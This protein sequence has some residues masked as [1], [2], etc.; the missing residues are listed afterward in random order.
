MEKLQKCEFTKQG[1][2]SCNWKDTLHAV[3]RIHRVQCYWTEPYL[4]TAE[5]YPN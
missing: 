1:I 4:E 2:L 3:L 5:G